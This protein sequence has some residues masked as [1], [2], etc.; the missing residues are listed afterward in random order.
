MM[1]SIIVPLELT[2]RP[3]EDALIVGMLWLSI[4]KR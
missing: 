4:V 1:R 2:V 3:V